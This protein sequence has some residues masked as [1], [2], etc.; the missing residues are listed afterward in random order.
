MKHTKIAGTV[1]GILGLFFTGI[2]ASAANNPDTSEGVYR[3]STAT[4]SNQKIYFYKDIGAPD[5][6]RTN[7]L[8]TMNLDGSDQTVWLDAERD[9]N[10]MVTQQYIY[11]LYYQHYDDDFIKI[12]N[13]SGDEVGTIEGVPSGNSDHTYFDDGYIYSGVNPIVRFQAADG[14]PKELVTDAHIDPD[15]ELGGFGLSGG[16]VYYFANYSQGSDKIRLMRVKTDG[17]NTEEL[18]Y[19][20]TVFYQHI[21][22][23]KMNALENIS[24]GKLYYRL[25]SSEDFAGRLME[26]DLSTGAEREL[27][28]ETESNRL[29]DGFDNRNHSSGYILEHCYICGGS[30]PTKHEYFI[31][32]YDLDTGEQKRVIS[33]SPEKNLQYTTFRSI[34]GQSRIYYTIDR[35]DAVSRETTS[36]LGS[37]NIDGSDAK[38]IYDD[39]YL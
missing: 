9:Y 18:Y 23:M 5:G 1:V 2:S 3:M 7:T 33:D 8:C 11:V 31:A 6:S 35:Y 37:V 22:E 29:R 36:F 13:F 38:I 14:A 28:I 30:D 10:V 24:D 39:A 25:D 19:P 12:Y 34:P 16:Y 21:E 32:A 17:S 20:D 26:L 27:F 15:F 4:E